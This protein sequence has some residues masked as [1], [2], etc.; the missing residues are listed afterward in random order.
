MFDHIKHMVYTTAPSY[1]IALVLYGFLG[2]GYSSGE[3]NHEM[4]DTIL[5]TL[6]NSFNINLI[7]LIPPILVILMVIKKVPAVPGLTA[8]ACLGALFAFLFQGSTIGEI[9]GAANAGYTASTG[10]ELV[11]NLVQKGGIQSMMWTVSLI[12]IA[13]CFAGI[14]EKSGMINVVASKLLEHAK[15][16]GSLIATTI[17]TAIFCNFATGVQYM[18]LIIPGRMYR[19]VYKDRGLAPKNLSRALEDSGTLVAPL[20]PWSTDAAFMRGTLAIGPEGYVIYSFL[21]LLSPI[22]SIIYGYLG[23]TIEKLPSEHNL[24]EDQ[25]SSPNE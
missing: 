11:D 4:I 23:F 6:S 8:G 24:E 1:V 25:S 10:V 16:D 2:M 5:N 18:A 3:M 12:L 17:G 13:L 20:V 7:L 15:S 14:V 9:V 19:D 21:N 22:I